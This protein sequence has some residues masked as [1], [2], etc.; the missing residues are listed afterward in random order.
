MNELPQWLNDIV[1]SLQK[2]KEYVDYKILRSD[3]YWIK[4][5]VFDIYA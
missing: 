5:G 1:P 2:K 3:K 4:T